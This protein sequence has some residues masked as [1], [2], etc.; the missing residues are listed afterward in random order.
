MHFQL[1]LADQVFFL[2]HPDHTVVLFQIKGRDLHGQHVLA[3]LGAQL[4]VGKMLMVLAGNNHAVDLRMLPEHLLGGH[5]DGNIVAIE[6]EVLGHGL[7][8]AGDGDPVQLGVG[9]QRRIVFAHVGMGQRGNCQI[10]LSHI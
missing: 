7:V 4:H 10:H 6:L 9:I 1:H 5:V 8:G 3:V 2:H